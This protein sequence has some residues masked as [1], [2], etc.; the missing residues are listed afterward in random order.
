MHHIR[1]CHIHIHF[2]QMNSII[3]FIKC[4]ISPSRPLLPIRVERIVIKLHITF[5]D[6]FRK[7]NWRYILSFLFSIFVIFLLQ[8]NVNINIL[9][10]HK[11]EV[12]ST[13]GRKKEL[14]FPP[15]ITKYPCLIFRI[16]DYSTSLKWFQCIQCLIIVYGLCATV[17]SAFNN[18]FILHILCIENWNQFQM[19]Q[20]NNRNRFF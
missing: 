3:V 19:K 12:R 14:S 18:I 1:Y 10:M 6:G 7:S 5:L 17:H 11:T 15:T 2:R 16:N 9:F 13:Q 4:T 8:F 20:Y